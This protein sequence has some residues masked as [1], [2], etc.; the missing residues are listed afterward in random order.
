[1]NRETLAALQEAVR[2]R[3]EKRGDMVVTLGQLEAILGEA[4]NPGA[5]SYDRPAP[6]PQLTVEP[7]F[8]KL[9]VLYDVNSGKAIQQKVVQTIHEEVPFMGSGKQPGTR[10]FTRPMSEL[11]PS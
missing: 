8:P 2:T 10:W 4:L 1:M 6:I 5:T 11:E 7:E 9:K 3:S